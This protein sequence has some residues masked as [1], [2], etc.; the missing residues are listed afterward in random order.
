MLNRERNGKEMTNENG[1]NTPVQL[2]HGA[3]G[4]LVSVLY[5]FLSSKQILPEIQ[6]LK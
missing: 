4:I 5:L 3:R 2:K 1:M 6:K